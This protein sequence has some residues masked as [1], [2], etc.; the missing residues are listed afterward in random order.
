MI[1][2]MRQGSVIVDLAAEA[3]G[4]CVATKPGELYVHKGV[5]IIGRHS[6]LFSHARHTDLH[7]MKDTR[8]CLL[9]YPHNRRLY[10]RIILPSFS[11]R[12]G[13]RIPKLSLLTSLTKWSVDPLF[14]VMASCFSLLQDRLHLL[15]PLLSLPSRRRVPKYWLLPRGKKPRGKWP[16]LLLEWPAWLALERES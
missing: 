9:V 11:S 13:Y 15:Q 8:T 7:S 4:N 12:L 3:G 10:I 1:Q 5:T 14:F 6:C 2:A 16:S